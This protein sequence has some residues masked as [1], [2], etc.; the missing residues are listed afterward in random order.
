M[1]EMMIIEGMKKLRLIEK[2]MDANAQAVQRYASMLSS[3]KPLFDNEDKQKQEVKKLIQSNTDLMKEYLELKKRVEFSNLNTKVEMGGITYSISDLLVIKRTLAQKMIN[4]YNSLNEN[5]GNSRKRMYGGQTDLSGNK[6]TVVRFYREEDR[7]E[8]LNKWGD[9]YDN[10]EAR[11]EVINAMN[12][13]MS[14]PS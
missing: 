12:P 9:L 10:I 14:L 13:L 8:G 3:D 11:L 5:E 1:A 2:K 7:N 6:P 4:T